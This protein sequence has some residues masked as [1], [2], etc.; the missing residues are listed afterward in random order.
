MEVKKHQQKKQKN[1]NKN[2]QIS[3]FTTISLATNKFVSPKVSCGYAP[4]FLFGEENIFL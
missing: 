1:T 2:P 4:V 3:M